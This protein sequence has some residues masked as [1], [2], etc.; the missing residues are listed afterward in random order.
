VS[1]VR[2]WN[3]AAALV[4]GLVGLAWLVSSLAWTA[5]GEVLRAERGAG[6]GFDD[7]VVCCALLVLAAT[8]GWLG[9]GAMLT[10][11][12]HTLRCPHSAAGRLARRIT[13]SLVRRLVA[14]ACGAAVLTAPAVSLPATAASP[15]HAHVGPAGHRGGTSSP[16]PGALPVPDR[17]ALGLAHVGDH[18]NDGLAHR[19]PWVR[20]HPGDTLWAIAARRLPP[21]ASDADV[22]T[23]W[24]RWFRRNR[25]LIG[26]D[27]DLIHPGTH[28]RV[29]PRPH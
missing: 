7:L 17:P 26:P 3:R 6:L 22:S 18:G 29:P 5:T 1:R 28:L 11:G 14:G 2:W 24:P 13:P 23:A 12:T 10:L 21:D 20:V 8:F 25:G 15:D 16:R 27:P 4:C 19:H 9:L